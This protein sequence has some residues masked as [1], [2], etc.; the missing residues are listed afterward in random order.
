MQRGLICG[1]EEIQDAALLLLQRRDHPH[2]ALNK[3][4]AVLALGA[5]AALAPLHPRTNRFAVSKQMRPAK[6]T[7]RTGYQ[8]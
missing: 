3:A 2:H 8:L 7:Q 5:K 1:G 6:L 4:R